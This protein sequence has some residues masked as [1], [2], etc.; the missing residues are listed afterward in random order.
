MKSFSN[1]REVYADTKKLTEVE[2]GRNAYELYIREWLD[3]NGHQS[4]SDLNEKEM[5]E[6]NRITKEWKR[7]NIYSFAKEKKELIRLNESQIKTIEEIFKIYEY[8]DA[9]M[10][11]ENQLD[12]GIV[13]IS[14]NQNLIEIDSS[15][16]YPLTIQKVGHDK[17]TLEYESRKLYKEKVEF[18][19]E[20]DF[21]KV[22]NSL[23]ESVDGNVTLFY[24]ELNELLDD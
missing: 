24:K 4:I 8:E 12:L 1:Y 13:S 5:D 22:F 17:N 18:F 19:N 15:V 9:K 7:G 16:F 10:K 14:Q 11:L 3:F 20:N 21:L 2:S 6:F 23:Y